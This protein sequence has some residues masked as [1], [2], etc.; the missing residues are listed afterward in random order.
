[1]LGAKRELLYHSR[2]LQKEQVVVG[3]ASVK[4]GSIRLGFKSL[5]APVVIPAYLGVANAVKTG[6]F[7]PLPPDSRAALKKIVSFTR[8]HKCV[9]EL[10]SPQDDTLIASITP[11]TIIEGPGLAR[12]HTT[13]YGQIQRVGGKIPRVMFETVSGE[14]IYCETTKEIAQELGHRLYEF[15]EISGIASWTSEGWR[16]EEFRLESFTPWG[17][18]TPEETITELKRLVGQYFD[19]I[20]DVESYVSYIRSGSENS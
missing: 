9:A 15:A 6:D 5:H 16:L 8:T 11:S 14:T 13:L 10:L 20:D 7:S 4:G 19:D 3:L 2:A 18:K 12:G 1:M 17:G